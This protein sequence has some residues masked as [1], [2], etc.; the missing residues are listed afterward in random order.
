MSREIYQSS[1]KEEKKSDNMGVTNT[2]ILLEMKNK[3]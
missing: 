3:G 2:K 1:F